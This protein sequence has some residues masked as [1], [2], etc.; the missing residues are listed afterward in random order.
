MRNLLDYGIAVNFFG[1]YA[2]EGQQVSQVSDNITRSLN[3]LKTLVI[4]GGITTAFFKFSSSIY[5][6]AKMM[7]QNF[8]LLVSSLGSSAK[9][10]SNLEWA[11]KKGAETPFGIEEVNSAVSMMTSMGFNKNDKMREE[12]FTAIGNFAGMKGFNFSDMMQ[13]VA[14]ASFGNWESLGD[15]FGIRKQT[16]GGMVKEQVGRTPEKFKGEEAD[17]AKSIAMVEK[18][19]Q[20]TEEYRMAIVKLI[21]VLGRD[22]M[23]NR[24]NTISGAV[25]NI[26]DVFQNF[27]FKMVGY[28]QVQGTLANTIKETIVNQILNPLTVAHINN[29]SAT[30]ES[31][32]TV[33]QLGRIGS[34]VGQLLI[35][36]WGGISDSIGAGV[37]TVVE[38]IDKLDVFFSDFK[39]NV[40][41][42]V[43]F[44]FLI[45]LEI[46]SF[47]SGFYKGFTTVFGFFLKML[48]ESLKALAQFAQWLGIG[49]TNS[50]SLGIVLGV[51]LGYLLG[52]RAVKFVASM[53]SPLINGAKYL[54][55]ELAKAYMGQQRLLASEGVLA[56]MSA[57]R[58]FV[59]TI[60]YLTLPLQ[61]AAT[62]SW[63]FTASL[64]ANPITWVVVAI[65]ALVAWIGYL[66]YNWDE[67]QKSMQGVSG[68]AL[69][70]LAII[71]PIVGIPLLMAKYWEQ[72]KIIV[73]NVWRGISGYAKSFWL[74]IR[75]EI[76]IP[77][78]TFFGQVWDW[79][80]QKAS[81]LFNYLLAKFPALMVPVLIFK[82]AWE[83]I[84]DI[85]VSV[86]E[87]IVKII[88]KVM[89]SNFVNALVGIGEKLSGMFGDSGENSYKENLKKYEPD[90]YE[91]Q[92]GE[93]T[94]KK[95]Y[96]DKSGIKGVGNVNTT[97]EADT[98]NVL[99]NPT[100]IMPQGTNGGNFFEQL[101]QV[102]KGKGK[103]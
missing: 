96:Q 61:G 93:K 39:N 22:G 74:F 101:S 63:A 13:R 6:T 102:N 12:V 24:L 65:I 55:A 45:R 54:I 26:D 34:A 53:F 72:L 16:I 27:M 47:L 85:F 95:L 103:A 84:K 38:Y 20:G 86:Y 59:T 19:K 2:R 77:M 68:E 5:N 10:L 25:A 64:L 14:K 15:Q 83:G 36:V 58:K 18:G 51:V 60:S 48:W 80:K 57:W 91:K 71:L 30:K 94:T 87:W 79:V 35:S 67:V 17:I 42:I 40:A 69:A 97:K 70:F 3:Q 44:I 92:F 23:L 52:I 89:D 1:N 7:E 37:S 8:A 29:A 78:R 76:L 33:D 88:D 9:A 100:I 98:K 41:P 11:R 49:K 82:T 99:N 46:E 50:E 32:T 43:L 75:Y 81:G 28:T 31:I 62:A 73:S 21:G 4:G 56:G 66:I 90:E